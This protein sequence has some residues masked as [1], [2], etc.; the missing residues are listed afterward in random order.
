[1]EFSGGTGHEHLLFHTGRV[2][3]RHETDIGAYWRCAGVAGLDGRGE[4]GGHRYWFEAS[5]LIGI[6]VGP[7]KDGYEGHRSGTK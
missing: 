2:E 7:R 1:M 4:C 6:N 5:G 3:K